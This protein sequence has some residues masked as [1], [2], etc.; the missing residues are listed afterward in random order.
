MLLNIFN[1]SFAI[2]FVLFLP[3]FVITS[4]LITNNWRFSI[5]KACLSFALSISAVPILIYTANK[6]IHISLTWL[7]VSVMITV[8]I[9]ISIVVKQ[10]VLKKSLKK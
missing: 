10:F 5:E 6:L 7:T 9:I 1:L 4:L 3:G 2:V 8:I